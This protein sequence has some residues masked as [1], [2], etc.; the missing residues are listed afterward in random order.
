MLISLRLQ[1]YRCFEDHTINLRSTAIMVGR[2]NA[3]KSTVIEALRLVSVVENRFKKL[4]FRPPPD[5]LDLPYIQRGVSPS[6]DG[7]G[8]D[9]ETVFH[10]YGAPPA[11]VTAIFATGESLEIYIG[12]EGAIHAL[13][14]DRD[15]VLVS[16]R[17]DAGQSA[18]AT[19]RILP[20]VAPLIPD[21]TILL[22]DYVQRH[23]SSTLSYRHF[24]NQLRLYSQEYR[25]FRQLAQD[26]WP[27]LRIYSLEGAH[28]VHGDALN[29]LVQDGDF[30]A[31]VARMGHGLQMWLQ[32]IWFLARASAESVVILDEPDVYM[33]A[34]LQR[35]VIRLIRNRYAQVIIATHSIE[36][37]AEVDPQE[38]LVIDRRRPVSIFA[39][40]EPAVQ[41]LIDH[42]GGIHNL[43][44]TRLWNARRCIL[45]EG[46]D[47]SILKQF[48]YLIFPNS[49]VV[50]DDI[51]NADIGGWGGWDYAVG[52]ALILKNAIGEDI[53]VYCILDRDYHSPTEIDSRYQNASDKNVELHIWSSKEIENYLFVPTAIQRII[54]SRVEPRDTPP[55]SDTVKAALTDIVESMQDAVIENFATSFK[56]SEPKITVKTAIQRARLQLEETRK[57]SLGISSCVSGKEVLSR[58]SS[59]AQS[60]YRVSFGHMAVVREMTLSEIHPELVEVLTAIDKNLSFTVKA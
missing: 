51:P 34:D 43:S 19:I 21:E 11:K 7:L 32:T 31:E 10:R 24:R 41:A 38:I 52:S 30:V 37:M 12:P 58:M 47:L 44:L 26:T 6:V 50:L 25:T 14:F 49:T 45:V 17:S 2:N 28:G 59:W 40:S 46:D 13:V 8:I 42:I 23:M 39:D 4:H 55:N 48:H 56:E 18:F 15:R 36:I 16:A 22:P 53:T 33:H 35:R 27:G 1:N 3:G 54:A 57:T 5:W 9:F 60:K 29:L 20:Q